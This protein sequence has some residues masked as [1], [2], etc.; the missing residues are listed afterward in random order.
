L[1]DQ[2]PIYIKSKNEEYIKPC[3]IL[4]A[5]EIP[6]P[7]SQD[8]DVVNYE[9]VTTYSVLVLSQYCDLEQD[10]RYRL[11]GK[12]SVLPSI[13]LGQ[14]FN[15][16]DIYDQIKSDRRLLDRILK[17]DHDRYQYLSSVRESEDNLDIGFPAM[18]MDSRKYYTLPTEFVY[19]QVK[20]GIFIK[21][22]RLNTPYLENV[23]LRF[24]RYLSRISLPESH[25]DE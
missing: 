22:T 15:Y 6:I 24:S 17:N 7:K 12:N 13:L 4:S 8:K 2:F 20:N 9:F 3:E 14:L 10:F 18:V 19:D 11:E 16:Q 21:R 5:V 1:E 25:S 23:V